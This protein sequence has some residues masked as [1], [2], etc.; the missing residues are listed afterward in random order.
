MVRETKTWLL[1]HL[2]KFEW[3]F[4]ALGFVLI[5]SFVYARAQ[6]AIGSELA[7]QA[8][9]TQT[10]IELN[11]KKSVVP[12]PNNSLDHLTLPVNSSIWSQ[13]R[14]D[15]FKSIISVTNKKPV[16]Q[17]IIEDIALTVPIFES[18]DDEALNIGIGRVAGSG[19]I[20]GEGNLVLAGHRDS[21]FRE[22]GKL[23]KGS[24][25]EL[26]TMK[27]DVNHYRITNTFITTPKDVTVLEDSEQS[28]LTLI[29]CYPFYFIG[30][31]PERYIV[32]AK[33]I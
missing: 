4:Y 33:L 16:A 12:Y 20:N 1:R 30:A 19:T 21:F 9:N 24:V 27:G 23:S 31:A 10:V 25:I 11:I 29:T 7:L 15:D 28:E 26:K 17:L 2:A 18:T 5:C 13:G 14:I 32:K 8:L 6:S 22:L 3:G